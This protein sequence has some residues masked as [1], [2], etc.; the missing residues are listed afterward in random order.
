MKLRV[1]F[2]IIALLILQISCRNEKDIEMNFTERQLTTD[3]SGHTIHQIQCFSPDDQ[4]IVYD[5]RNDDG[6]IGSTGTIAM[7][8]VESGEIRTLYHTRNQTEYGPGVGAVTFSPTESQ[9]LFIH[10]VRNADESRPYSMT[11]RTGV[12]V[13]T[14]EPDHPIFLDGRNILPPFTKG[15]LRGGTHAHTWSP[16]GEW[17]SFTYNDFIMEQLAARDEKIKDLRM[18]GVMAPFGKVVVNE[19][20][21]EN[22]SGEMFAV[23]VSKVT[24]SPVWG[25]DEI[26]KACEENWIGRNGYRKSDGTLQKRALAFLGDVRDKA[27]NKVT[28][29]FV[30]DLPDDLTT[31]GTD[32]LL[33]GTEK[34]RPGVPAGVNQR[35]ITYTS[36]DLNP[37]V[38][39]PRHWMRSSPDGS[40]IYFLR[41]DS[42]DVVQI[43]SVSPNG[44]NIEQETYNNFSVE[45]CLSVHPGGRYIAYGSGQ[46]IYLTDVHDH[47]TQKLTETDSRGTDALCSVNWSN[48]GKKL[49][50]NRRIRQGDSAYYQICILE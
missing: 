5:T 23:V 1:E 12:M 36:D 34:S 14:Q 6:K 32:G 18:V 45:T 30:A 48:D 9:V 4:W 15:A 3:A 21:T 10:G 41:K 47:S 31:E 19:E 17:V 38:Q 50:F 16:D 24:E 22:N 2:A 25:S 33:E 39:G 49:A 13:K 40:K 43:Y 28:E 7:V 11:R 46:E 26:E 42:Q 37:G 29:V 35:R 27:G 8:N 44:G 20:N